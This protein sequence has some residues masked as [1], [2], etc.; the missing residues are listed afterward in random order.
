L[1]RRPRILVVGP[2]P[3]TVG[4]VTSFMLKLVGSAL[5]REFDFHR[6]TTSRPPKR[7]T[8]DNWGYGAV[9]KG[10]IG[11]IAVG[12]GVTLSHVL[13][14]PFR[15]ARADIVQIQAS[16]FLTFWEAIYYVLTAKLLGRPTIMR[17]G[18]AFDRFY[19]V[20]PNAMQ[21]A[22]RWAIDRPDR[23]I[24]QSQYWADLVA[25]LGRTRGVFVLPNWVPDGLIQ[26]VTRGA[27]PV[28]C[29]FIAGSE[30]RR[31]GIALILETAKSLPDVHFRIVAAPGLP[32]LPNLSGTGV[33]DHPAMLD[34]MRAADIFALPSYGEGF[35]NS[36]VEAMALGLPSVATPVGAVPEIIADGVNGRLIPLGDAKSLTAGIAMLASDRDLRMD[37]G[38]CAQR[39][40]SERY[41]ETQV[42]ARLRDFYL[43]LNRAS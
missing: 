4:G 26:P 39:T 27:G 20:S 43:E 38:L 5:N 40:V 8:I 7:G 16:D 23:L 10:G 31:K 22:I 37:M 18:G 6:F 15:A 35:P 17:L 36:L 1:S 41:S 30:A 33:L 9:L 29:L 32:P 11:R 14:F 21:T 34:E 25:G 2:W 28:T 3:P 13:A 12:A 19:D 42:I 24:V